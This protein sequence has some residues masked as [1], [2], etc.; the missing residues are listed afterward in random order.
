MQKIEIVGVPGSSLWTVRQGSGPALVCCH[1]GPGLRDYLEPMAEMVDDLMTVYRYDQRSCGRS[2]GSPPYDVATAVA[3]LEALREHWGLPQWIVMGHSWGATLALA[4]CLANPT[5]VQAMIYLSGIGVDASW[6]AEFEANRVARIPPEERRRIAD[7]LARLSQV[8]GAEYDAVERAYCELSWSTDI[9]DRSHAHELAQQLFVEN[10]HLHINFQVNKIPGEDGEHFEQQLN[11]NEQVA[12]IQIPTL[13]IHGALDLR[14]A[15]VARQL[16]SCI[17]TAIYVELPD[18]G[19]FP[20]LEKPN[21]LRGV[22]RQFL[23]RLC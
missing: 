23:E 22:L 10:L 9:V 16:A 12:S 19:H 14:P 7:L 4:Y 2:T 3:D 11:K 13:V 5:R 8:Q 1:G 17:P 20:W 18:V 15:R 6:R 21:L